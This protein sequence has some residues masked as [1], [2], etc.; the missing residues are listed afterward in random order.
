MRSNHYWPLVFCLLLLVVPDANGQ[1][2]MRHLHHVMLDPGHGGTNFGTPG[3][4]GINEK[5]LTLPIALKVEALL[6][7]KTNIK[8]S[9]TRRSDVFVGLRERTRLANRAQADLFLSIHCNASL[10]AH[11]NGLEVYFLSTDS[12]SEEIAR[13][14]SRE[15]EGHATVRTS[16][17]THHAG[18]LSLDQ[19]L[20]DAQMYRSHADAERV[21]EVM[22]DKLHHRLKAPRRGVFQAPFAVLKEAQMPAVVVEVGYLTHKEEGKKL[23]SDAYQR[24]IAQGIYEAIIAL[25][26]KLGLR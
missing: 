11:A 19:I 7:K 26:A 6:R 23:T 21:A 2:K 14:V 3:A 24:R 22:L 4:H 1:R 20:Q 17:S 12:A 15:Q 16:A 5:Y 18:T 9:L 10:R 13:L 25:D 8:V